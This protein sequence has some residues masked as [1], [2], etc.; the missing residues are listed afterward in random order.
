ME[1]PSPIDAY[2]ATPHGRLFTRSWPP[3]DAI[4][5]PPI[6][7]F[8]DSLGS[9][10][11]WRDFP[12]RLVAA[13]GRPAIAYDRLGFG[14]SDPNPRRLQPD[15]VQDEAR[16]GLPY[17]REALAADRMLL[18][19][20]SVGGAMAIA[21]GAAFPAQTEAVITLA[22]QTFAEDRTL[23]GIEQARQ[24]FQDE[25]QLERLAKYH[26]AKT[27]WVLDAWI[28][29]W[30]APSFADW[31]LDDDLR[32]LRCPVLAVHG[33]H[34]EYGSRAHPDRIAALAA[35]AVQEVLLANCHHMPHRE[36]PEDVLRLVG[37]F[38]RGL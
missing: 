29:T 18:F 10:D 36:A 35:G 8:H 26:G 37:D 7:L 20:H 33:D 1:Y 9:V 16:T 3:A 15:F 31:S 19:G 6:I 30:L 2:V 12:A 5:A 24:T 32:R 38:T 25:T 21:A 11:Q 4:Q 22:A 13:T 14:R 27:R 17:I 34:D 28:G 23:A